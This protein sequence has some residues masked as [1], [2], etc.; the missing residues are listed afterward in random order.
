MRDELFAAYLS[1][2]G[3][4]ELLESVI[5]LANKALAEISQDHPRRAQHLTSLAMYWDRKYRETGVLGDL[6]QVI[7]YAEEALEATPYGHPSR[8]YHLD[9]LSN[10]LNARYLRT[11]FMNDLNQA[12]LYAEEALEATPLH[13]CADRAIILS[14]LYTK[15]HARFDRTGL[16][17]DPHSRQRVDGGNPR[18]SPDPHL[19]KSGQNLRRGQE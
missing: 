4:I 8:P 2:G 6:H 15:L 9:N 3:D 14:L 18:G 16:I 12:I 1:A 17:A 19:D 11:G 7:L 13:R 5:T 10:S